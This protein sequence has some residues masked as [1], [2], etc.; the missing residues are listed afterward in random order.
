MPGHVTVLP[1]YLVVFLIHVLAHDPNFPTA[2]CHDADSCAQFFRSVFTHQLSLNISSFFLLSFWA[3]PLVFSLRALIDFNDSDGTVDLVG[4]AS[5]Y[6][7]SIFHAIKKAEDA[8]DAQSTPVS[9]FLGLEIDA[10]SLFL[11]ILILNHESGH[12][13]ES[14]YVVRY[15]DFCVGCNKQSRCL[16]FACLWTYFAAIFTL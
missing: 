4:K 15:W 6:L 11:N 10:S 14:T 3:S 13:A 8:V 2:E 5:S 1:V 12:I 16:S 7:R 9:V